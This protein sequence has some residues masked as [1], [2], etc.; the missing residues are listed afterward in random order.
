HD[1]QDPLTAANKES[2]KMKR[3]DADTSYEELIQYDVE[4]DDA[5]VQDDDMAADDTPHHDA[6]PT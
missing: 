4:D 2:K 3:K 6:A 1:N 5:L